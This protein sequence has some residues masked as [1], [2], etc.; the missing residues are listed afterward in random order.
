MKRFFRDLKRYNPYAMYA[1]KAELKSSVAD[2]YL[3]WLWWI[4]DPILFMLIYSF[5][6]KLVFSSREEN[7]AVFV[8][9]G[10]TAWDFFNR[11]ITNS[12]KLVRANK[13]TVTKIYIPKYTLILTKMYVNFFKMLIS[14]ALVIVG[15]IF[16]RV[17]VSFNLLYIPLILATLF[18]ITFGAATIFMHF[19]VFIEDLS[20]VVTVLLRL[21]FYMSG[22]FYSISGRIGTNNPLIAKLLNLGNPVALVI[23]SL[24]DVM[25]YNQTPNVLALIIWL[26]AGVLISALG[27]CTIYKYENSYTKVI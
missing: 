23:S 21:V 19:G 3:N 24:R 8:I 18:A 1:A 6:V 17:P 20:N 27:V 13:S 11:T 4:L 26:V 7:F 25:L 5:V 9:I 14:F 16:T 12:V 22:I 15:M 2:S 10:L